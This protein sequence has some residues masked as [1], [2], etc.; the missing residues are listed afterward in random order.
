ME[1]Y[2]IIFA[3]VAFLV[4]VCVIYFKEIK[5]YLK[6]KL[7]K[8]KKKPEEKKEKAIKQVTPT[9]EDFVPLVKNDAEEERDG[10]IERLFVDEEFAYEREEETIK[11]HDEASDRK[12]VFDDFDSIFGKRIKNNTNNKK[13]ISEH[14]KELPPE[15]KALLIDNVLKRKDDI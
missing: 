10:S 4:V 3:I 11:P 14:I 15:V 13:T 8:S 1:K 12:S 7:F 2:I 6:S 9:V 5:N